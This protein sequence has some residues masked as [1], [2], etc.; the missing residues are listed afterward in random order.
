MTSHR[1]MEL[2]D[3]IP[4]FFIDAGTF[5]RI[6][7]NALQEISHYLNDKKDRSSDDYRLYYEWRKIT[8]I[9]KLSKIANMMPFGMGIQIEPYFSKWAVKRKK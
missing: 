8:T 7:S 5:G 6:K 3:E 2:V 4:D 1:Y 9:G